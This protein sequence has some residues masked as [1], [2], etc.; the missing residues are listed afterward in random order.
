[1][2]ASVWV[3]AFDRREHGHA[4]SRQVLGLLATRS[5][6]VFEPMLVLAEVAGAISRTRG[7]P[8]QAIAFAAALANLPNITFVSL[9]GMLAQEA[10]ALAA[11]HA[12]RGADAVYGAVALR[13]GSTLITLDNEHLTRL[14]GIVDARTPAAVLPDLTP[15][16]GQT[17]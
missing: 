17:P 3:N 13:S 8:V 5:L 1:M 2:D 16:T 9:D 4:T 7:D 12:L 11:H 6:P 15:P 14:V 10:Q